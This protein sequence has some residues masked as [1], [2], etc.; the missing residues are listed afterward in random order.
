MIGN[1]CF[2]LEEAKWKLEFAVEAIRIMLS[3]AQTGVKNRESVGQLY[4]R[5][6]TA[7]TVLVELATRLPP[8][9]AS[10]SRVQ[11]DP[12]K[13]FEERQQLFNQGLHCIGL[14]HT[15][16]EPHPNP[17][18]EDRQLSRNYANAAS[19]QVQGIVFVIVGTKP[20]PNGFRVWIDDGVELRAAVAIEN[21]DANRKR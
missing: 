4:T 7:D 8:R 9:A 12:T 6:L 20:H 3:H 19:H 14:W 15:H 16:P 1:L 17:S 21:D 5:D 2:E 18:G 11:F 13:A 10:W